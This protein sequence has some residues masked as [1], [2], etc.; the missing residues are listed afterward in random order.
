MLC[1]LQIYFTNPAPVAPHESNF[2]IFLFA[3]STAYQW[4]NSDGLL[5]VSYLA[6]LVYQ[7]SKT[8]K[9]F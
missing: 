2:C 5:F 3:V 1:L 8:A 9:L 7:L 4:P 6:H